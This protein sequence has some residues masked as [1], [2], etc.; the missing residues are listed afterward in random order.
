MN[1]PF[2]YPTEHLNHIKM[3]QKKSKHLGKSEENNNNHSAIS[4]ERIQSSV[5][6]ILDSTKIRPKIAI[7]C[8][9][10]WAIIVSKRLGEKI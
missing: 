1:V 5:K 9:S 6:Y 7:I 8:G 3:G 10:F 2:I 4:F